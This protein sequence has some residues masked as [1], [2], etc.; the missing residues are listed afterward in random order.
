QKRET[1]LRTFANHD[2]AKPGIAYAVPSAMEAR[3]LIV[4]IWLACLATLLVAS[5]KDGINFSTDDAM[6][7]VEGRD[8]LNG[9]A[10]FDLTQH[11]LTPPDGVGMRWS[12]LIDLP[13]ALLIRAGET[14][15]SPPLAERVA[16]VVW[17]A[18]LL[19]VFLAGVARLARELAGEAAARLAL[20]FAAV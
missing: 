20:I 9:Q 4:V 18:A 5:F 12:R 1:M 10:W 14:V 17:P 6:R 3:A 7:L 11:R 2:S 8:L 15:L 19:L 13:L 16:A